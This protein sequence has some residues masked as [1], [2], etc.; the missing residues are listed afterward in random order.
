MNLL[1]RFFALSLLASSLFSC[2]AFSFKKK[3][4][5]QQLDTIVDLRYVDTYPSFPACDSIIDKK[6]KA[7]CFGKTVHNEIAKNLKQQQ[8]K[9][10]RNVNETIEVVMVVSSK[11][12]KRLKSLKA[13]QQLQA[14]I[15][16]LKKILQESIQ[17]LPRVLPATKRGIPVTSQYTLPI[18]ISLEN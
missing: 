11:G 17:K 15:P 8:I 10:K 3:K 5:E 13:T 9:V 4:I 14:Q 1:V 18:K 7:N 6:K 12:E 16:E 2:D